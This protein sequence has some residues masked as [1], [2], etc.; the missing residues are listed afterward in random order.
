[1]VR[2]NRKAV[3]LFI[4]L[5]VLIVVIILAIIIL[6]IMSSQSRLTH[7]Q[8][9][10]IQAYYAS[11]AGMNLA[12]DMLGQADNNV[13]NWPQPAT[14]TPNL[15]YT[16]FL[17]REVASDV[18]CNTADAIID[19]NIPSSIKFVQVTVTDKT[20]VSPLRPCNPPQDSQICI[21]ATA[22]Y[23]YQP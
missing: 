5:A 20:A 8:V 19:A 17:C 11:L 7:H 6:S 9:S 15:F 18:N 1:M 10:R 12:Y 22:T 14:V 23:T 4:V 16:R 2:V 21:D 3:V 13:G